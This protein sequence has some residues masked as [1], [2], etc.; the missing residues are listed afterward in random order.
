MPRE[1]REKKLYSFYRISQSCMSNLDIF[2]EDEDRKT[3]IEAFLSSKEKHNFKLL[4]IVI[5]PS[6]YEM[7]IYDNGSDIS[8]IMK[9]I[10]ISFAMKFKCHH[11]NCGVI[12]KERYKSEILTKTEV[13]DAVS[14]LP[15]CRFLDQE[16]IDDVD[17]D[18]C[19]S[20]ECIDCFDKAKTNLTFM[21]EAVGMTYDEMLK[22]KKIRND[23]IKSIRKDSTLSLIEIGQ[24]FG[25][26]S[27]SAISK[28]LSR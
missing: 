1:K 4:G 28:I 25:G 21:T 2:I 8:K 27:E 12:F 22:K 9:S 20:K 15:T 19:E 6:G 17:I 11:E 5:Y 13:K 26:L 3:L 24:L 14:K 23:F 18:A 7:I 16:W 10:N